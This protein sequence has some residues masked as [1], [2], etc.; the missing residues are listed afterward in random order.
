MIELSSFDGFEWDEGNFSKS[1]QKHSVSP[2]ESEEV[3]SNIPLLLHEDI[4]HSQKETRLFCLGQTNNKRYLYTV[5]TIRK[6]KFIRIISSRDMNKKETH[7]YEKS[8]TKTN[9]KI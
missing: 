3:F 8:K 5:F 1:H 7:I 4:K 2:K 6:N 9:P